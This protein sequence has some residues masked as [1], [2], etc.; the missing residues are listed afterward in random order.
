MYPLNSS[1][2]NNGGSGGYGRN[3]PASERWPGQGDSQLSPLQQRAD[4]GWGS[5]SSS[6]SSSHTMTGRREGSVSHS[7]QWSPIRSQNQSSRWQG[8]SSHESSASS[9][10]SS[11]GMYQDRPRFRTVQQQ[12]EGNP[13]APRRDNDGTHSY[14]V[15]YTPHPTGTRE[16]ALQRLHWQA[17]DATDSSRDLRRASHSTHSFSPSP[18]LP[19]TPQGYHATPTYTSSWTSAD[20]SMLTTPTLHTIPNATNISYDTTYSSNS[21]SIVSSPDEY[22]NVEEYHDS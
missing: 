4:L 18:T 13:A 19:F 16:G 2:T 5:S 10:S 6:L 9:A 11:A 14:S 15:R 21:A 17:R 22:A 20:A 3:L 7:E 8:G 1:Q 12:Y